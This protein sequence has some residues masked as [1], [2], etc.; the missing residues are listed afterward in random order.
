MVQKLRENCPLQGFLLILPTLLVTIFLLIIPLLLTVVT[1]FGQ[2]DPDGNVIYTFTLENYIRL[3]G[4]TE[5]GGGSALPG[6]FSGARLYWPSR[7]LSSSFC[8]P[9]P[10]PI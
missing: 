2:R 9:I 7:P 5:D 10:W 8:W 1:S 6:L 3:A 4:F